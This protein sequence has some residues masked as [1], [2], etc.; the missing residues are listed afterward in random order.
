[1]CACNYSGQSSVIITIHQKVAIFRVGSGITSPRRGK[2][3]NKTNEKKG[4]CNRSDAADPVIFCWTTHPSTGFD[5]AQR[6]TSR[7]RANRPQM[8]QR[9]AANRFRQLLQR[10]TRVHSDVRN[11]TNY[12]REIRHFA[13]RRAGDIMNWSSRKLQRKEAIDRGF[14]GLVCVDWQKL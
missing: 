1:M 14:T 9:D 8:Q 12:P 6:K 5:R 13:T 11:V 7:A 10:L 3:T 4:L 2:L